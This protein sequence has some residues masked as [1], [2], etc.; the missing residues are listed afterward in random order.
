[1]AAAA[2]LCLAAS[3]F[4]ATPSQQKADREG[5]VDDSQGGGNSGGGA[6]LATMAGEIISIKRSFN[7]IVIKDQ[8][9]RTEKTFTVKAEDIKSLKLG[10]TVEI[11]YKN[12]SNAAESITAA[13]PFQPSPG[14]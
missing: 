5:L 11:K 7:Q 12:G 6:A 9:L 14:Y 4:A 1:M 8:N 3:C 13:K 2:I 10:D